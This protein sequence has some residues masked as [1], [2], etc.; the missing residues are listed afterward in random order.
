M[1]SL[2]LNNQENTLLN[3]YVLPVTSSVSNPGKEA[4]ENIDK[5]INN[6]NELIITFADNPIRVKHWK[7]KRCDLLESKATL[8]ESEYSSITSTSTNR[9]RISTPLPAEV[10]LNHYPNTTPITSL[11]GLN[12]SV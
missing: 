1:L 12:D 9:S 3:T 2:L 10:V 6:C 4:T 11:S 8:L 5:Q 7:N